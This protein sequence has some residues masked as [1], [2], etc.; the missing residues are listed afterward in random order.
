MQYQHRARMRNVY[1]AVNVCIWRY[2]DI[3]TCKCCVRS[4]LVRVRQ[5]FDF[6][7]KTKQEKSEWFLVNISVSLSLVSFESDFQK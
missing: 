1:S 2:S 5:S 6:V 4:D 3:A 7:V